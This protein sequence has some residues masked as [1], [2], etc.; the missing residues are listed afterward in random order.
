[1]GARNATRRNH[2]ATHL[3][4]AALRQRLGPHVHQKGS[5]VAPDRLRFDFT[6]DQPIG[7][8]ERYAIERIVNEQ[9]YRN[10]TVTTEIKNTQDAISSGAMAL[11]GEKYGDR[12][13]VVTVPGFSVEL[14]GGTHVGATGD[15]GP[16]VITE[17]S[18]VAAGIRRIEART[19]AAAVE[20][21]HAERQA[22]DRARTA[23]NVSAEHVADAVARLQAD[24]K[25][26][27]RENEHLK[28]QAALG[29]GG[30]DAH[31]EALVVGDAKLITKRVSGLD[32]SAL[33][34]LSDSLRD[35]L[36][37]GVV[38]LAADHEGKVSLLVA[39]T[40]DLTDRVKAGHLVKEL[41][42][43]VGGGGGGRADFAEAGGKDASRIDDMLARA[44]ELVASAMGAPA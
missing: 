30:D 12:V 35:R 28:M 36:G 14:C 39:V 17:E 2:T 33:R 18:G 11:F 25:R 29:G 32:K 16:F 15:I 3:V 22:L 24:T 7:D 19:G 27:A 37:R 9:V 21:I 44:R 6:S 8:E 1:V 40:K 31:D 5:L 42:P 4:H 20:W 23:L 13:R 10:A 26:L 38:V 34:S 43:I 41:A